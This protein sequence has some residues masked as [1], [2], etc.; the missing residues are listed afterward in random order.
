MNIQNFEAILFDLGGVILNID[1]QLTA[2]AFE[3][4]GLENFDELYSKAQQSGLF[5]QFEVGAISQQHFINELLPYLPA[6]TSPNKVVAAWNAMILE[7][8]GENLNLLN[9]IKVKKPIFLLSNT[10]EIHVQ[11]FHRKLALNSVNETLH[12]YFE[13]VY[14]SNELGMRKPHSETFD[15]V[16]KENNL[17]PAKTLF[18]DDSIQ[19]IEG[20]KK[21]GLQTYHL[22]N[23]ETIT[24]LFSEFLQSEL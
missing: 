22:S 8:P 2:R 16:C 19:H 9:K 21:I 14:F 13:K 5:D 24:D 7:F 1:Y 15:F 4:I 3:E 12:P 17:S 10:N 11:H 6:G 18:I 20:A 23:G